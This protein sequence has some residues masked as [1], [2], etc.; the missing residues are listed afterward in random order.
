MK[1][2]AVV[3]EIGSTTTVVNA[4]TNLHGDNP[5]FLGQGEG[6]TSVLLGDVTIG[7]INAMEDLKSKL[8]VE[9]LAYD[10]FLATSSAA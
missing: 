4:F 10:E 1:I 8:H 7:L 9:E 2:D 5:V 6:V 3:A